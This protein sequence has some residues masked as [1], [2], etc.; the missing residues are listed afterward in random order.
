MNAVIRLILVVLITVISSSAAIDLI[1]THERQVI[2]YHY[3]EMQLLLRLVRDK[4]DSSGDHGCIIH[5]WLDDDL[6]PSG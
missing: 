4:A 2:V 1:G 3:L 6:D 5:F